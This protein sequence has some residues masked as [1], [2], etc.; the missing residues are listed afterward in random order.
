MSK[1]RLHH[2]IIQTQNVLILNGKRKIYPNN[3]PLVF[4]ILKKENVIATLFVNELIKENDKGHIVVSHIYD[5]PDDN[6]T[7]SA[8]E[9]L[10]VIRKKLNKLKEFGTSKTNTTA[11]Y[12]YTLDCSDLSKDSIIALNHDINKITSKHNLELIIPII[13]VRGKKF[14]TIDEMSRYE[15]DIVTGNTT[16]IEKAIPS[17]IPLSL[18]PKSNLKTSR[19]ITQT[20][21]IFFILVLAVALS[22]I[23]FF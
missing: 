17:V 6:I 21:S 18:D 22:L 20:A 5:H 15:M 12:L 23:T 1:I 3:I 9:N 2:N 19:S 10:T 16:I 13:R 7:L 8:N 4:N 14:V 11:N